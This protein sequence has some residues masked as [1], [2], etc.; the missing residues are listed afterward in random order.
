MES[1]KY[2]NLD[3]TP[4]RTLLNPLLTDFYQITMI[5]TYWKNKRHEE[6]AAYDL[7]FRKCPFGAK[8]RIY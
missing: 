2:T 5:Y 8:V 6:K 3:L 4:Y 1:N 7:F